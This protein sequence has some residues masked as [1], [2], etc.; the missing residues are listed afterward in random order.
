MSEQ[1]VNGRVGF[2]D[3]TV[4]INLIAFHTSVGFVEMSAHQHR[5]IVLVKF[6]F[7][8]RAAVYGYLMDNTDVCRL[9]L[10]GA[11]RRFRSAWRDMS[12]TLLR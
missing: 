8:L 1:K 3:C 9:R 4:E 12:E 7:D 6:C 5:T 11:A 10:G 2:I